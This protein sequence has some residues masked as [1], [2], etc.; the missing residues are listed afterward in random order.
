[1]KLLMII[2]DTRCREELEVVLRRLGVAAY[3]EIPGAHGVGSS[4]IR[5]G[6]GAHP[7]TSSIF[8]TVLEDRHVDQVKQTIV[9]FCEASDDKMR[10]I[11]WSVEDVV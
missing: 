7:A 4:G 3:S 2:V 10:M 6:S 9:G 8:F 5:M 1:M 11:Q